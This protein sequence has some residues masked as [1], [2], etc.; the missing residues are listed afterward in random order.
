MFGVACSS[1]SLPDCCL[2]G[3]T[4]VLA[5][6]MYAGDRELIARIPVIRLEGSRRRLLSAGVLEGHHR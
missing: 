5:L 4:S 1:T 2:A 3:A 6:P